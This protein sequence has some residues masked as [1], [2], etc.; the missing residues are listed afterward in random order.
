MQQSQIEAQYNKENSGVFYSLISLLSLF[1][2]IGSI[3]L[4]AYVKISE[5]NYNK[6]ITNLKQEINKKT[7]DIKSY[8][9]TSNN[10]DLKI[11]FNIKN[12]AIK[13]RINWSDV[14]QTIKTAGNSVRSIDFKSFS[15]GREKKI[16]VSGNADDFYRIAE[17]LRRL[18]KNPQIIQPFISKISEI[19]IEGVSLYKF[20]LIFQ[21]IDK[22]GTEY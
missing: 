3:I 9:K 1:F 11:A 6:N 13:Y 2:F 12:A 15:S 14:M 22:Q 5:N 10:K 7:K 16:T 21:Y 8:T 17:L 4:A 18:K 19:K 20:S